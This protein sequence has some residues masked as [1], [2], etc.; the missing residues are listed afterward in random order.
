[1]IKF[2]REQTKPYSNFSLIECRIQEIQKCGTVEATVSLFF[3]RMLESGSRFIFVK[4]N[5]YSLII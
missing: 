2:S 4:N 5:L 1:M 3:Y